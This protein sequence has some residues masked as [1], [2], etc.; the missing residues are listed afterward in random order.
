MRR[1]LSLLAVAVLA[2][3]ALEMGLLQWMKPL[4]DHEIP[5]VPSSRPKAQIGEVAR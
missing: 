3:F 4:E 1:S 5:I 2:G